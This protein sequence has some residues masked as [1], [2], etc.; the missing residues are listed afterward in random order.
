MDQAKIV[1]IETSCCDDPESSG[2]KRIIEVAQDSLANSG[3]TV[4]P[5]SHRAACDTAGPMKPWYYYNC[6]LK[7]YLKKALPAGN[8]IFLVPN[9][10][11]KFFLLP[12]GR[13]VFIVHDLIPLEEGF[14][15]TGFRKRVYVHKLSLLRAAK[16]CIAISNA[17]A[18][19][20]S[21]QICVPEKKISVVYDALHP[22]MRS[23]EYAVS[24]AFRDRI[25]RIGDFIL[26]VGTGEPRKNV[27]ILLD[28][29]KAIRDRYGLRLVLFGGNWNNSGHQAIGKRILEG[30]LGN[31]VHSVGRVTDDELK[32]L[33]QRCRLFVYPSLAEG[34]GLPPLEALSQGAK[35]LLSDLAVFKEVYGAHATLFDVTNKES[36]IA[37]IGV[38]LDKQVNQNNLRAFVEGFNMQTYGK[39]MSDS[40]LHYLH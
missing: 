26:A 2:I 30:A 38:A 5:I 33:Y 27:D 31:Y 12:H 16:G 28:N 23:R 19:Q 40:L 3:W 29:Y 9:N 14:G 39:N 20:L 8:G 25:E 37:K 10:V 21:S 32:Y 6:F 35:V 17:V 13:T 7:S 18:E 24:S 15:Y 36:L 34:F 11:S 1:I 4:R 22:C